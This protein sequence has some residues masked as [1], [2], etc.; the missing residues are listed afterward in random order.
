M[1]C[2]IS[3]AACSLRIGGSDEQLSGSA[4]AGGAGVGGVGGGP[5]NCGSGRDFIDGRCVESWRRYDPPARVDFN[6]VVVYGEMPTELSLPEPPKSGFRLIVQPQN[7][8]PGE[9]KS[10]C[11]AWA[12]PQL[13]NRYVYAARLYTTGGLHHSNMFGMVHNPTLGPSPGRD[14]SCSRA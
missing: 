4:G 9:E 5:G 2:A 14:L 13:R 8:G 11:F 1:L 10:T 3:L 6:N 7:L 12:Y